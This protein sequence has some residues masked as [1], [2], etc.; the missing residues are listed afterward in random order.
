MMRRGCG[1]SGAIF[2]G[3]E[4]TAPVTRV[5]SEKIEFTFTFRGEAGSRWIRDTGIKSQ[6]I[7]EGQPCH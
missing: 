6:D 1:S 5:K 4:L 2:T 3:V 7:E